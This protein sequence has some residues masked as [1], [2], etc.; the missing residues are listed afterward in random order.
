MLVRVGQSS[1][2]LSG[3]GGEAVVA[4]R[5]PWVSCD[6]ALPCCRHCWG[7]YWLGAVEQWL[8]EV[9]VVGGG[10]TG[11]VSSSFVCRYLPHRRQ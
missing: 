5:S 7:V 8:L 6:V 1:S 4:C 9:L 2:F 10:D 11:C 3:Y